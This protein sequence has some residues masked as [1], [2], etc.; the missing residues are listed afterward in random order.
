MLILPHTLVEG[1]IM[2]GDDYYTYE[3]MV[4]KMGVDV[5]EDIEVGIEQ[6]IAIMPPSMYKVVLHNDNVTTFEFVMVILNKI[7]H[8][9]YEDAEFLTTM[10]HTK[11]HGIAGVYTK[12]VAEEKRNASAVLA[13]NYGYPLK[14]TV[15][16]E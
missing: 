8:M 3:D 16:Q 9:S 4:I 1:D 12:E 15:E 14:I 6:E 13:Q 11:G 5:E 10:I 2:H 7:F